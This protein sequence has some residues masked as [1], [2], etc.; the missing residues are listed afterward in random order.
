M[1]PA[2]AAKQFG[3]GHALM[4]I[5]IAV[6]LLY[7]ANQTLTTGAPPASEL[8]AVIPRAAGPRAKPVPCALRYAQTLADDETGSPGYSLVRLPADATPANVEVIAILLISLK[9]LL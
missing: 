5:S 3:L 6:T 2:A 4:A 8:P 1:A 7:V 9:K